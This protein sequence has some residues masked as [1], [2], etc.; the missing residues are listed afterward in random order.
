MIIY[1]ALVTMFVYLGHE[2]DNGCLV[3]VTQLGTACIFPIQYSPSEVQFSVLLLKKPTYRA[4]SMTMTC[5]PKQMPKNGTPFSLAYLAAAIFP[6]TPLFPKPPGTTIP[7]SR[8][9][10]ESTRVIPSTLCSSSKAFFV[11]SAS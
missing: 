1:F 7:I 8:S 5:I 10:N 4:Y 9:P 2:Y 3:V 6:S 11:A